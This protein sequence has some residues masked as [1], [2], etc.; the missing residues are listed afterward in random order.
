MKQLFTRDLM[1]EKLTAMGHRTVFNN[2]Q[3]S[4]RLVSCKMLMN[5]KLKQSKRKNV[6]PN[7]GKNKERKPKM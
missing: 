4:Y 1:T 6:C 7:K 3:I 2:E 5:H